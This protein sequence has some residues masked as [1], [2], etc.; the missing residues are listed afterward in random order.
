MQDHP[1]VTV[2]Q[3]G[4]SPTTHAPTGEKKSEFGSHRPLQT[5]LAEIVAGRERL[6]GLFGDCF[7]PVFVPPWN[8][9]AESVAAELGACG[10]SGLSVFGL[11]N[12]GTAPRQIKS[13]I[14]IVHCHGGRGLRDTPAVPETFTA[15]LLA[16]RLG[17]GGRGSAI[18]LPSS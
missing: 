15:P 14:D 2:L 4:Y 3:H 10:L 1:G 11:A 7:C 17:V 18:S 6:T 8:R 16:I 5:M 9:I 12:P 13:H